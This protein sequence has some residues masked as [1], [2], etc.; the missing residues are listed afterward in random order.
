MLAGNDIPDTAVNVCLVCG[1][2][3]VGDAPDKCPY[4]GAGKD[5]YRTF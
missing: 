5:Q 4:C 1:H 2:T 3:V